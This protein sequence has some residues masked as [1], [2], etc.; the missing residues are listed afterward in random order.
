MNTLEGCLQKAD[1]GPW[2]KLEGWG[3]SVCDAAFLPGRHGAPQGWGWAVKAGNNRWW[4]V[5]GIPVWGEQVGFP[6]PFWGPRNDFFAPALG[7]LLWANNPKRG[8]NQSIKHF[9]L[10]ATA[11]PFL[12]LVLDGAGTAGGLSTMHLP[13]AQPRRL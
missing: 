11:D 3:G 6:D 4:A 1:L 13:W 8:N 12:R 10:R 7:S 2:W 5:G 9:L